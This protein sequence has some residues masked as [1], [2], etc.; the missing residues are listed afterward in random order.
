M[1]LRRR[2]FKTAASLRIIARLLAHLGPGADSTHGLIAAAGKSGSIVREYLRNMEE[3]GLIY[4]AAPATSAPP[5]GIC[6]PAL[7]ALTGTVVTIKAA[8]ET[9]DERDDFPQVVVVRQQWAP[10]HVRMPMDSYLF[11]DRGISQ[12]GAA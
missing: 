11:G 1:S 8:E 12:V 6:M 7:W 2:T 3:G 5:P 4:R 9:A 10:N